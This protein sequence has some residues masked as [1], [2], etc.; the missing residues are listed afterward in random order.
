MYHHHL[1]PSPTR[2]IPRILPGPYEK[3]SLLCPHK[4]LPV[5]PVPGPD[6]IPLL[7]QPPQT[8]P[9]PLLLALLQVRLGETVEGVRA[10]HVLFLVSIPK[11]IHETLGKPPHLP[12]L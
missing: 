9:R 10:P 11:P 7:R 4:L 8:Q 1:F 2:L 3:S 12:H 5:L 6:G